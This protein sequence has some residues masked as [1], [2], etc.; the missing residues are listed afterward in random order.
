[1]FDMREG[2]QEATTKKVALQGITQRMRKITR[3]ENIESE[4]NMTEATGRHH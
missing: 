1:M 2:D 3:E 4:R